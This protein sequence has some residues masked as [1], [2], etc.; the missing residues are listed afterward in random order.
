[1]DCVIVAGGLPAP[2]DPLFPYTGGRPKALLDIAGRPLVDYVLQAMLGASSIERI[3]VVGLADTFFGGYGSQVEFIEDQGGM[4][5]NGLAGLARLRQLRPSTGH[6]LFTSADIPSATAPM[7]DEVLRRCHPFDRSVYYFMVERSVMEKHYPGSR[8][9][10]VRLRDTQVA[11]ADIFIA[12]ASIAD[13]NKQLFEDL[14]A[15]RKNALDLARIAG[16]STILALLTHRLTLKGIERRASKVL[17]A[18]VTVSLLDYPQLAMD[19][20]RPEQLLL[21]RDLLS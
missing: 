2:D 8:R 17:G 20:D 5:A 3:V 14:S 7:I 13:G 18:P 9:T 12:S 1:M 4:V 19:V 15:G 21:L 6:V 16:P 10:Y 11:G